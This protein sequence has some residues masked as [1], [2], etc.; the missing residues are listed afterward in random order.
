MYTP[1]LAEFLGTALIIGAVAFTSNPSLIIAAFALAIGFGSKL[2]GGHF[3][4][5][6]TSWHLFA[7]KISQEKALTY[8]LA[9][10]TPCTKLE[11]FQIHLLESTLE[12][13]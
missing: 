1:A 4:P 8:I 11:P 2:S 13:Y 12:M 10:T 7:G 3:N 9:P 6:V 5:A